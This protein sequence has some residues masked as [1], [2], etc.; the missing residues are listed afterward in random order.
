V[1]I[2]RKGSTR[3]GA[4]FVLASEDAARLAD[5]AGQLV[6]GAVGVPWYGTYGNQSDGAALALCR[7]RRAF[8]GLRG[9]AEE[10][11]AVVRLALEQISP[12]AVVWIAS[13]AVS[14][15]DESGFPE[16]VEAWFPEQDAA[17]GAS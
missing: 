2:P 12:E 16:A 7:L 9:G 4:D 5:E 15:L 8:A 14:Y 10:G 6:E 1:P 11:D 13:R 17:T 3:E